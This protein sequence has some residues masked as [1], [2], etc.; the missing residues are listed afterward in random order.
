[1]A[2]S[3]QMARVSGVD[4]KMKILFTKVCLLSM[5]YSNGDH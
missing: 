4:V 2:Q 3:V 5:P 1:M